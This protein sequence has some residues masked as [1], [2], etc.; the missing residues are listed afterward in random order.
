MEELEFE[1]VNVNASV[2]PDER[3]S[4]CT[5]INYLNQNAVLSIMQS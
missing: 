5:R 1:R 3:E 4:L 2:C